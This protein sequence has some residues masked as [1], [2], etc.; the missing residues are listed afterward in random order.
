MANR[1]VDYRNQLEQL[2]AQ[3]MRRNQQIDEILN[4]T[5]WR[6]TEPVRWFKQHWLDFKD[7]FSG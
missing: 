7:R 6:L 2:D 3:I 4:S 1:I 5:S